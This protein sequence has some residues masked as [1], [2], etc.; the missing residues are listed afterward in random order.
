MRIF[1]CQAESC[2]HMKFAL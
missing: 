1:A 2:F